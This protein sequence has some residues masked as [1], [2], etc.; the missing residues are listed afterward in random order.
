MIE[1]LTKRIKTVVES[2]GLELYD[3][4]VDQKRR[5]IKVYVEGPGGVTINDCYEV[6]GL[7]NPIMTH[8]AYRLEVSSPGVERK[9][10]DVDDYRRNIG[11]MI[12]VRTKEGKKTGRLVRV[13]ADGF[14]I[15]V[16]SSVINYKFGVVTKANII[17]SDDELFRR[18]GARDY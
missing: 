2:R 17:V 5:I 10:R 14:D 13:D 18:K 1:E 6:A 8:E 4:E 15:K 9:L 3:L 12:R 16:G 11:R 7:L